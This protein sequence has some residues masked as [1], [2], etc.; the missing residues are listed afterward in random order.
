VR[1]CIAGSREKVNSDYSSRLAL[2]SFA[3]GDPARQRIEVGVVALPA[4]TPAAAFVAPAFGAAAIGAAA[5]A[6]IAAA[7]GQ[8]ENIF[9]AAA[10][11]AAMAAVAGQVRQVAAG[12]VA[13]G[14]V[15]GHIAMALFL[16]APGIAHR[17]RARSAQQKPLCGEI[18]R[19]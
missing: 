4:R 15:A 18:Q 16:V 2:L 17:R 11:A 10:G 9:G 3:L 19:W 8:V 7:V 12:S 6:D 5:V 14:R 13:A 1:F